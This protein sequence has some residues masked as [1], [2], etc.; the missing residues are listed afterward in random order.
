MEND[1]VQ[2]EYRVRKVDRYIVTRFARTELHPNGISETQGEYDHSLMAE[3]IAYALARQEHNA[4]G[5]PMD[6]PRIRYPAKDEPAIQDADQIKHMVG[7]FLNW[8]LPENFD[9]DAGISF[10]ALYNENTPFPA[11]HEP[12]G[13]NLFSYEQ[14][15]AMVRHMMGGSAIT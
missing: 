9:P 12:V 3:N 14:A 15:D 10:K 4:L 1:K 5:W 6:D 13:T 7:R 11:R 8:K 2:I